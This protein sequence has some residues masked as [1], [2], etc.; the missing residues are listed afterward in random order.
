M[1]TKIDKMGKAILTSNTQ[2]TMIKSTIDPICCSC[3]MPFPVND[4][5]L[6]DYCF[7]KFERD[8]IRDRDWEYSAT[9]FIIAP[10]QL[11]ALRQRVV[12]EYGESHELIAISDAPLKRKNKR[13]HS[14]ASQ[15]KAEIAA[16]AIHVYSTDDVL[17]AAQIFLQE[18]KEEWVNFSLLSQ[19]L[20][21]RFF[22]L[23]PKRLGE[24]G[25]KYTSLLKFVMD[26]PSDFI[27]RK[28]EENQGA[29]WI[30]LV[31]RAKKS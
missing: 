3:G 15:R 28:D 24:T 6:C 17:Q 7:A 25:K 1:S 31:S 13:S 5:D 11:E 4:L 2:K 18:Q 27:V 22:K 12:R 8:L 9:A 14:R 21:E 16:K 19:Y 29:Y 30:C 20:Y 23:T 10:D 26:Y